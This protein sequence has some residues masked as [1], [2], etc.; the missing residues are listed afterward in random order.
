LASVDRVVVIGAGL[1]GLVAG[2]VLSRRQKPVV[3]LD[4]RQLAGGAAVTT[5]FAPGFRA[6]TLSHALGPV[7]ARVLAALGLDASACGV[8]QPDPWLTTLGDDG[9]DV[10]FSEDA[11][12]TQQSIAALSARDAERWPAFLE[13]IRHV[14]GVLARVHGEPPPDLDSPSGRDWWQLLRLGGRARRLGRRDLARLARWM[15]MPVADL[16]EEWFDS[17]LVRAAIAAHG[18]YG[19][20]VGPRSAGTGA[21]LLGRV[22][23]D[24]SPV[25][26]GVTCRGGPGAFAARLEDLARHQGAEIRLG[27]CAV[28]ITVADGRV[29]G[30]E[31]D[32]GT[33]IEAA[34]VV[35]AIDPRQALLGLLGPT[36]LPPSMRDDMRH[37]RA[38]G[39]TAKVNLALSRLPDRLVPG[40]ATRPLAG[41]FLIAPSLDHLER[42]HDAGKYGRCAPEPWLDVA[43]PTLHDSSLAPDGAHVL[44]VVAH[45]M[46]FRLRDGDW[47]SHAET[48]YESVLSTLD[49]R[50]PG[51]RGLIVGREVI[52]PRDL[53]TRWGLTGG[54]IFHGESALDQWW[55]GRPLPALARYHTPVRGL[56]LAS[57]GT[58]PGGGLTGLP[59]WLAA[60]AVSERP[61]QRGSR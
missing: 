56:V 53:E 8:I 27:V 15:T 23:A 45:V 46:P 21:M 12:A 39:V 43:V 19:N 10:T 24:P 26:G 1:N 48:M 58:H 55:I 33:T 61:R 41:R 28:R 29:T 30:V 50:L 4:R 60:R 35:A 32:D 25:G 42:A 5:E 22:A 17:G 14:A 52:T 38:R 47:T 6:P 11:A 20:P 54:H 59:G 51:I 34:T 16:T 2:C 3:I 9:R 31:L 7:D 57:A 49:A 44:S 37:Y 36:D 13:T 40:G 18:I